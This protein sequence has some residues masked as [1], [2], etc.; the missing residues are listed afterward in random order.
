[1]A[2]I[3]LIDAHPDRAD[4]LCHALADAY[5]EAAREAGHEISRIDIAGLELGFLETVADFAT[6]PPE[7]VLSERQKIAEADHLCLIFPLWLGNIPAKA[8]AF[9]ELAAC[10]EFFLA[11]SNSARS[12][13]KQMMKG[14][15]VRIVVTMGMPG[16]VYKLLFDAGA[17]KAL[18]RGLFGVSGFKPVRH[19]VFG[20]VDGADQK[21]RETWFRKV[22]SLGERAE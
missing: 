5:E 2:R 18:E 7:P 10:G 21:A 20:G 17:L 14:R 9:L 12:W 15:S 16:P 11:A 1:M 6:P 13:P 8:K 4:H 22:K 19:T 3:C